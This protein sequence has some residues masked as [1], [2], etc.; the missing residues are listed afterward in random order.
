[1]QRYY[2]S[3]GKV[4]RQ[5]IFESEVL[6]KTFP[7]ISQECYR[8]SCCNCNIRIVSEIR[9]TSRSEPGRRIYFELWRGSQ[10]FLTHFLLCLGNTFFRRNC[11][12]LW[13]L[14]RSSKPRLSANDDNARCGVGFCLIYM[15]NFAF[16]ESKFLMTYLQ[17]VFEIPVYRNN[18]DFE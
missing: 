18:S 6:V 10:V 9:K 7:L 5:N 17:D 12:L 4:R 8:C 15:A 11:D 13:H 1:M 16:E 3:R 2:C 14:S